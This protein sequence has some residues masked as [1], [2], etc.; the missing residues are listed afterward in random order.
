MAKSETSRKRGVFLSVKATKLAS[1]STAREYDPSATLADPRFVQ[2]AI[3]EALLD[4]DYEAAKDIYSAHLRVLN[5]S[6]TATKLKVSR[7]HVYRM[8]KNPNPRLDT[9]AK[10]MGILKDEVAASGS[11]KVKTHFGVIADSPSTRK[12]YIKLNK[13]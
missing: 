8:M 1:G 7:Q 5:R 2:V 12:V 6:K 9:L 10:F 4:G 13:G 11:S 3:T